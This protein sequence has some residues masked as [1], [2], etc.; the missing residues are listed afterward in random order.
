[1]PSYDL[2]QVARTPVADI[3]GV[4]AIVNRIEVTAGRHQ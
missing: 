1:M 3:E 2:K 4:M